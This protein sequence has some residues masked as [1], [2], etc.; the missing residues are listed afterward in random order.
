VTAA[1][2]AFAE[3]TRRLLDAERR[4]EVEE[5]ARLQAALS[6]AELEARGTSILRLKVADE[7]AGLGGR[8]VLWLERTTGGDLPAHRLQPGD[9]VRL[10]TREGEGPPGEPTGVVSRVTAR[11]IA[12]ALDEAPDDP[13]EEPIRLDRAANDLTWR[14]LREAVDRLEGAIRGPA[15]RLRD[16]LFGL[17]D[18]EAVRPLP[19]DPIDPALDPS[20]RE[21][22][23]FALAARDAALI[24]GP[25]GTGKTTALVEVIRQAVRRGEKVLACAPSNVATDNLVERLAAGGARVVRL[26]HPARLLPAVLEHS[27]DALVEG[28]EGSRIVLAARRELE[29]EE[30]R[31]RKAR[32]RAERRALR[33]GVRRLRAEVRELEERVV[34]D[35]LDRAE[36]VLATNVGAG[37]PLLSGIEFDRVAIDEAA[38]ALEASSW[39]PILKGRSV[40]LA[41]DHRQL[42][43]TIRSR[44]A[45]EGGLGVTLFE[46]LHARHGE[47]IARMLTVQY[48]M[49]ERIMEWPSRELY[50]GRLE[51]H[52]SVAGHLL[53]DLPGIAPGP[54]TGAPLVFI[55][56]AG[57]D[58]EETVEVEGDSKA[59]E[60]EADIAALHVERLIAAGLAAEA[61]AVITPYN[62]QVD[63]LRAR[64]SAA[65][66]LL[67]IGSVDGFQGR[68]KEAVVISLVRSN[69]RGDVGF[70][71]DDRRT[72][73]AVTRARR[74]LAVIGDSATISRHGFLA[75]LVAH[76]EA[77]GDYR[78]AWEYR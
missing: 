71:A 26:G 69:P 37:D 43:P 9:I 42:P 21:A 16:V 8:T 22:A 44:E 25:P 54:D 52:P 34:R 35:V 60:G 3:T 66:P 17:R 41:G 53:R 32:D 23:A 61:I 77:S 68:E 72:N 12:V 18:P 55:D 31:V 6:P 13:L 28:A 47:A 14:R 40:V 36:V 75:R 57:C 20:Q 62:A 4:A 48:R 1:I 7:S 33:D 2:R 78:S 30:R 45:A 46:R 59:N 63:R 24:H 19:L 11:R 29:R 27:L 76:A 51:A 64:L 73:V 15:A 5:A 10:V 58:L 39:I 56:T 49:H 38:Q 67:E 65:H 50:G 70:L 74:H